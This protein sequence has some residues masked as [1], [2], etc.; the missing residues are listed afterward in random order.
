MLFRIVVK[1]YN[2]GSDEFQNNRYRK[3]AS[4]SFGYE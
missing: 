3:R 2:G 4:R 1:H